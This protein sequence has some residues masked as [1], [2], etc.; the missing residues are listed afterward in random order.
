[1]KRENQVQTYKYNRGAFLELPGDL[2][3]FFFNFYMLF[4]YS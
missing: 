2:K 4:K 1:M 3:I